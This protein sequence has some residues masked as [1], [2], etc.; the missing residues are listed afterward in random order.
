[1]STPPHKHGQAAS[2]AAWMD[3]RWKYWCVN[4][5][6]VLH[7]A[8]LLLMVASGGSGVFSSPPLVV[9]AASVTAPYVRFTGMQNAYRFFAPDPGPATALWSRLTY[10]DGTIRWIECPG[11][12][13]H[14]RSLAYHR[15]LYPVMILGMQTA[16]LG[17]PVMPGYP[18]LT[19]IGFTY[20]SSFARHLAT[21]HIRT[22]G[23]GS[24]RRVRMLEM[25]VVTHAIRTPSQVRQGWQAEDLR[26][27]LATS[28]GEFHPDGSLAGTAVNVGHQK[29]PIL[30]VA[31]RMFRDATGPH[32]DIGGPDLPGP[33]RTLLQDH[34]ELRDPSDPRPMQTRIGSAVMS[35]DVPDSAATP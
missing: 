13:S 22:N 30:E 20:A 31:E 16:P 23:N 6:L 21:A 4:T 29:P 1:M 24:L 28:L 15:E 32:A 5:L 33:L 27:Y 7:L 12:E 34:P 17:T 9:R 10:D 35:K 2:P 19:D 8:A 25:L 11:R 3:R 14:P 18:H 26:L